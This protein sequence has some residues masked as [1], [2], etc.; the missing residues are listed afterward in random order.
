MADVI[1]A[2]RG[3]LNNMINVFYNWTERLKAVRMT[4]RTLMTIALT[5]LLTGIAGTVLLCCVLIPGWM[6]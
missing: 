4:N 3:I 1:C 2:S 6:G 5:L